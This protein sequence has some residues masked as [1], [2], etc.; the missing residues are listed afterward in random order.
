[1][2]DFREAM[3][4]CNLRDLVRHLDP[5]NSDHIPIVLSTQS[6]TSS[7]HPQPPSFCFEEFWTQHLDCMEVIRSAWAHSVIGYPMFQVVEKIKATCM[8]LLS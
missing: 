2:L 6:Q 7:R 3:C 4:D 1:M 8:A 5:F